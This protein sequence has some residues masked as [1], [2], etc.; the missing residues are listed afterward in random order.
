[1]TRKPPSSWWEDER[2]ARLV[3]SRLTEPSDVTAAKVRHHLGVR[4]AVARVLAG[5][6]FP[7]CA[8][9]TGRHADCP[10]RPEPDPKTARELAQGLDRWRSRLDVLCP[11]E[12]LVRGQRAG[13]RL[14]LPG[15]PLWPS[16]MDALV[17]EA[18]TLLWVAGRPVVDPA[19]RAVAIVGS[20]AC[21]SYGRHVAADLASGLAAR[22]YPIVSGAAV[23]IDACAHRGALAADGVTMAVLACGIDRSYPWAHAE[24]LEEIRVR[25]AVWSESPPGATPT[26]WRFLQRNRLIAALASTTVVVEAAWRS[27]ALSTA[28]WAA[29][30]NRNVA[31]VPG[32]VTS[33]ASAGCHRLV[34][35]EEHITLITCADEIHELTAPVGTLPAEVERARHRPQDDVAPADRQ[36]WECLSPRRGLTVP[37]LAIAAGRSPAQVRAVLVRLAEAGQARHAEHEETDLTWRRV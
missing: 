11:E 4:E 16:G 35:D 19:V 12:D 7:V 13:A 6:E 24:L 37:Q 26:R 20:R 18:P 29:K 10:A 8:K 1:M 9:S 14:V 30:L 25:G 28:R 21:T 3:W 27:G 31:V 32:P 22:A 17:E 23:G 36:V 15:D 2:L 33:A 34:R 5:Q